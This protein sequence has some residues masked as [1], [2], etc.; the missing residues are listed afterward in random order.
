MHKLAQQQSSSTAFRLEFHPEASLSSALVTY[1]H[2]IGVEQSF[3]IIGGAIG[4]LYDALEDSAIQV[5][6]FRHESGAAF[7][8][9]EAHFATNKPTLVFTTTGPGLLNALTGMTAAKWDGAKVVMI[10]G[11]TSAPQRGRWATQESSSYTMSQD[12][13]YCRGPLFDYGVRVEHPAEFQAVSRRLGAGLLRPGGF[14]AHVSI[15]ISLQSSRIDLPPQGV[16]TRVT[17]PTVATDDLDTCI[18]LLSQGSFAIWLGFGARDAAP[19]VRKLIEKTGAPVFC[20]PRAK[21]I[22]PE[23]HPRFVGVTG[24]GGHHSVSEYMLQYRPERVLVLGTRLGEATSFWDRD[25][26]P[27]H[28]FVH[29]DL[30]PE[31]P[32]SAYP[33]VPT[34]GIQAEVGSFLE[35]LIDRWPHDVSSKVA[36]EPIVMPIRDELGPLREEGPVRPQALMRAIQRKV[37]NETEA[38]VMSECGNSFAWCNHHLR[39]PSAKRYRVSTLFGSMGHCAAGVVGAAMARAGKA[40]AIT[41]DGSMLMNSEI[42]T[43]V[44]YNT[45][46]VWIVLNDAGYGMCESGQKVLGLNSGQLS[47]PSVDFV[48]F[49][50]SM[51]ADGIRVK[52]ETDLEAALE[53]AMTA[54]KPFVV[55]VVIDRDEPS[56][57]MERFESLL[58]QGSSKSF[59]GWDI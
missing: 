3:G 48:S 42:S 47:M 28:G 22:I 40:V 56:P 38:L 12:A 20:S 13:L 57:L 26:V 27:E 6:H 7:A 39:F 15:P 34:I 25:L 50:R 2:A 8:A 49:A 51:G 52:R 18:D 37:V 17:A 9:T 35:G 53:Q 30:D 1:L 59:A 16:L 32:G 14:I 29:V 33:D 54:I 31:V 21:G 5:R 4:V 58:R 46:A 19:A 23:H 24:I 43:A 45:Q 55:D 10:S 11:S 41:G 44:Q 36:S